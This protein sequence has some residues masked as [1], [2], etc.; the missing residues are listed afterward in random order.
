MRLRH[1]RQLLLLL[2]ILGFTVGC[3]VRRGGRGGGGGSNS[4]DDDAVAND[5][6]AV[7]D[8]DDAVGDD[9]DDSVPQGDTDGDG[10][11]D[12]EEDDLGTDPNDPDTDGDGY[13]DG[14]EVDN[15]SDPTNPND[16]IFEGMFPFNDD[17]DDCASTSFG[18]GAGPGD[19]LPCVDMETQFGEDY[20]LWN[21]Q[22]SA[23]YLVIDNSAIWCGPCN[24]MAEWLDGANNGFISSA[25]DS[26]REAVWSGELRWITAIFEDSFSNPANLGDL[27]AWYD[28]YPTENVLVLGDGDQDM[29]GWIG[30]TGIPS[31]TLVRLDTMELVIVDDT[32]AV[33]N[34]VISAL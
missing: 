31:L 19:Q 25:G 5:D 32:N 7:G 6:D 9:D 1:L 12:S 24:M 8:D 21:L 23:E 3:T 20:N 4:D 17:L 34:T 28:A 27:Q 10:L 16:G 14:D 29:I 11:S 15:N 18:W 33:L 13:E 22:G 2:L 30:A 26:I